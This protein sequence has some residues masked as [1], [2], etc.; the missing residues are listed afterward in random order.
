M[1]VW[2]W[3]MNY[4]GDLEWKALLMM[5]QQ[6]TPVVLR[7][8]SMKKYSF[9]TITQRF[10]YCLLRLRLVLILQGFSQDGNVWSGGTIYNAE[11]G[12]T[13]TGFI[14]LTSANALKL[15]GCVMGG[16]ICKGETWKREQ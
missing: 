3:L 4:I 13:Y 10:P 14:E 6:K 16:L 5:L 12:K 2:V 8:P 7:R 9:R 15:E 1:R 11:D